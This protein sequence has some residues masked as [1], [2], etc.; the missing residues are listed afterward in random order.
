M[1]T[2]IRPRRDF[3]ALEARRMTAGK[4]FGQGRTQAE[5]VSPLRVSRQTASRWYAAWRSD[6][7]QG[8]RGAGRAG[9]KPRLDSIARER[10]VAALVKGATAWGFSTELWT[11]DRVA[12]V[13]WKTCGVRHSQPQVW[14]ILGQLGWSRQRPAR[15]A[16]ERDETAI[17]RWVRYRWPRVKKTP[18]A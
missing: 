13:I 10:V 6:G 8:L 17:A 1:N 15:R 9:R 18:L 7:S 3:R 16:K 14:R 5:V 4:L 11:L 2:P 12:Q